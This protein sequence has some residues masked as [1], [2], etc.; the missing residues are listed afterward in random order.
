MNEEKKSQLLLLPFVFLDIYIIFVGSSSCFLNVTA[1]E[2]GFFGSPHHTGLW[3]SQHLLCVFA[4]LFTHTHHFIITIIISNLIF[5]SVIAISLHRLSIR[6][7]AVDGDTMRMCR[8]NIFVSKRD[9]GLHICTYTIAYA[10]NNAITRFDL[11]VCSLM[12]TMS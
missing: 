9:R 4:S 1:V 12:M 5:F 10:H 6:R 3:L 2:S 8:F 11:C 7:C